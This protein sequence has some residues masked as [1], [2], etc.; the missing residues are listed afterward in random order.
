MKTIERYKKI[1]LTTERPRILYRAQNAKNY[2]KSAITFE[3]INFFLN[4]Q[5]L[6]AWINLW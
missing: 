6:D 3:I 5:F 1:D 2:T 4:L